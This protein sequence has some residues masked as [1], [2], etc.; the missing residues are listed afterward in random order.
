M[1]RDVSPCDSFAPLSFFSPFRAWLP[2]VHIYYQSIT[3]LANRALASAGTRLELKVIVE[4]LDPPGDKVR[5]PLVNAYFL[6]Y[7]NEVSRGIDAPQ[8]AEDLRTR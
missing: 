7:R 1:L 2:L 8:V 6:R 3:N 5:V 4:L